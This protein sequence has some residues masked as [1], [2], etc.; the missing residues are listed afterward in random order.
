MDVIDIVA[1]YLC[2]H[3]YDGLHRDGCACATDVC[4]A[5]CGQIHGDCEPGYAAPCD[6]GDH[7]FHI[8]SEKPTPQSAGDAH[9]DR[10]SGAYDCE[11]VLRGLG[12]VL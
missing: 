10:C 7:D 4:L 11:P 1:E 5:E 12:L 3:G 2:T 6:C 8:V 9:E